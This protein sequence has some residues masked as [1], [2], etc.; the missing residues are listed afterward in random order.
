MDRAGICKL[1]DE[2][3]VEYTEAGDNIVVVLPG[4]KKLKTNCIFI[5]QEGMFR[6]EAFVARH[7]EEAHEEVYKLLLHANRR[8]FGV[9]YTLDANNDV[10]LVGQLPDSTTADDLQ[11]VLGQI[12]ERADSDFNRIL[13]RGFASSIRHEWAWRLSRGEPTMNLKAFA[14]LRPSEQEGAKLAP[15]P[16]SHLAEDIHN[17]EGEQD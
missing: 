17:P 13:E 7:V 1:L 6:V 11:R 16:G 3:E 10:Y 5:P 8:A 14:H 2:A 15:P 9:H 4:E 12:L